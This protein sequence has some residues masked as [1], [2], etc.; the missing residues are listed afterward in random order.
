ME[1]FA[2][3]GKEDRAQVWGTTLTLDSTADADVGGGLSRELD[4]LE[5]RLNER[6]LSRLQEELDP[7]R[8]G[9]VYQFPQQFAALREALGSLLSAVFSPSRFEARPLL[10]GVYFTSGTQKGALSTVY[11]GSSLAISVWN[12]RCCPPFDLPD[13]VISLRARCATSSFRKQ[14]WRAPIYVGN[15]NAP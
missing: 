15:A 2:A 11:S 13:A 5:Q 3:L 6:L 14:V 12:V 8:R 7:A 1:F 4:L 9:V 10:R